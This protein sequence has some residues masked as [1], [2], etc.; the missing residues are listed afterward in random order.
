MRTYLLTK[1]YAGIKCH[2]TRQQPSLTVHQCNLLLHRK[3]HFAYEK[4]LRSIKWGYCLLAPSAYVFCSI[5]SGMSASAGWMRAWSA[6]SDSWLES[7]LEK[8]NPL[9][10]C[11]RFPL[12]KFSVAYASVVIAVF[13]TFLKFDLTIDKSY[14]NWTVISDNLLSFSA[15]CAKFI[16]RRDSNPR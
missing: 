9:S 10:T 8:V 4:T 11:L 13:F 2:M 1:H 7:W 12:R 16:F 5:T 3:S 6:D 14:C 15:A